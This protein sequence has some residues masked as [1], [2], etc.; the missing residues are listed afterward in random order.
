MSEFARLLRYAIPGGVFELLLAVGLFLTNTLQVKDIEQSGQAWVTL[1]VA[2][3]FPLGFLI[4]VIANEI[5]WFCHWAGRWKIWRHVC[6]WRDAKIC[7]PRL[8]GRIST[9]RVINILTTEY[10][11]LIWLR[12]I[13]T[14]MGDRHSDKSVQ[15]FVEVALRFSHKGESYTDAFQRLRSLADLMNGLVNAAVAV[16]LALLLCAA[17]LVNSAHMRD[18]NVDVFRT[19][20]CWSFYLVILVLL[21]CLWMSE[22]RL[23]RIAEAFAIGMIRARWG[24]D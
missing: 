20:L 6:F 10:P 8:W 4:S 24:D 19:V 18:A 2:A 14:D 22:R 3:A 1:S 12:Q 17:L 11:R 13:S 5:A 23:A 7:Q 16:A 21:L 15:A 9:C